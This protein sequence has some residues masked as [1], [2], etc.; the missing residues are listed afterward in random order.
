ME[1]RGQLLTLFDKARQ[2]GMLHSKDRQH[3]ESSISDVFDT[4]ALICNMVKKIENPCR[5]ILGRGAKGFEQA[6][7]AILRELV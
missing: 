7:Q 2:E 4:L 1:L 3:S 6:R 5:P